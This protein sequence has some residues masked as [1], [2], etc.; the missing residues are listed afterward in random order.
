VTCQCHSNLAQLS[1]R[2][3]WDAYILVPANRLVD[4]ARGELVQL[5]VVAEDDDSNVDGAEHRELM[6]LLEQAAFALKEGAVPGQYQSRQASYRADAYTERFRS[7]LMALISIF[8][9]PMVDGDATRPGA[10]SG[11]DV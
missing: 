6:R 1:V 3:G 9:R 7:S 2:G 5:L 4:V 10:W 8:L 11:D